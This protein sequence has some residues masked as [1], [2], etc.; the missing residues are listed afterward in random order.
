M[1]LEEVIKSY[2]IEK[3]K[4][5]E[6][7]YDKIEHSEQDYVDKFKNLVFLD[8]KDSKEIY[9]K[10]EIFKL[11]SSWRSISAIIESSKNIKKLNKNLENSG[12][13]L[14]EFRKNLSLLYSDIKEF[15][16][17]RQDEVRGVLN[18]F[19][20]EDY[21]K[22]YFRFC[23]DIS[24]LDNLYICVYG[25]RKSFMDTIQVFYLETKK[26]LADLD[27]YA[28]I[29]ASPASILSNINKILIS[30]NRYEI[31]EVVE[32]I[33]KFFDIY[34]KY[35]LFEDSKNNIADTE[36]L[37]KDISEIGT[38]YK[39]VDQAFNDFKKFH[40]AWIKIKSNFS[41]FIKLS[42]KFQTKLNRNASLE[43]GRFLS[44][45]I[46]TQLT[47]KNIRI[48][49]PILSEMYFIVVQNP[50]EVIEENK[51][52]ELNPESPDYHYNKG[53]ELAQ[54]EKYE[55]A[56][57]EY[58][59][60]IKLNS[61]NPSYY[62][63]NAFALRKLNRLNEAMESAQKALDLSPG[64]PDYLV[65]YAELEA[66][67]DSPDKGIS[68]ISESIMSGKTD[69]NELCAR[70]DKEL[71]EAVLNEKEKNILLNIKNAICQN[72]GNKNG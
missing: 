16:I 31:I 38:D 46:R 7:I 52:T 61:N 56:I 36:L 55:E 30:F 14:D 57:K 68:K 42:Q 20:S 40:D 41:E 12:L 63:S 24:K 51:G 15:L 59:I 27:E 47:I 35:N 34:K 4:E 65:L 67:L 28:N 18:E 21:V 37:V 58:E 44:E 13:S 39:K 5:I 72:E 17:D 29:E 70:V 9:I 71:K 54:S 66:D 8:R 2:E 48:I 32:T 43:F 26:L 49:R 25:L 50:I 10:N 60:A 69:K 62:Y 1:K 19:F 45:L 3:L 22:R 6:A 11:I 53:N 33:G 23:D 64:N